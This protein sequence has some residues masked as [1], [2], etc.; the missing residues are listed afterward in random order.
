MAQVNGT[1]GYSEVTERFIKATEAIN[2]TELHQSIIEFI[3]TK[4]GRVLDV[5]AGIGRD[6]SVLAEMGHMVV[7]VEPTVEFLAAARKLYD[8]PHIEWIDD[9]LPMLL[10][11]GDQP[12]PFDFVLAS[13]VWHH[14]D[15]AERQHAMV[16][17][18][19][20]LCP[21]GVFALSLRHGPAG[22][23][24][25]VFSTDGQRTA[26]LAETCGLTT[27]LHLPNQP[28]LMKGKENVTWTRLAFVKS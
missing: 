14:L 23:G 25:H 18:S 3:P 17:I 7:A 27:L 16:R 22:A 28:S 2:F 5:G 20:L 10:K 13:A 12:D 6:A 11:L 26:E 1:K 21:Q 19:K 9:S 4:P 8:S 15:D 24:T